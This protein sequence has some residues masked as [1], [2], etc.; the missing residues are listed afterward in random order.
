MTWTSTKPTTGGWYFYRE[1][2]KNMDE[3]M[4]AWVF[5]H[6]PFLFVTLCPVQE[7]KRVLHTTRVTDHDGEW[8]GPVDLPK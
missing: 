8:W 2:G 7:M 6:P 5:H 1:P 3:P 4:A